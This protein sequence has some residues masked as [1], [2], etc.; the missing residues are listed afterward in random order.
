M[1]PTEQGT[2]Y[3]VR[4]NGAGFDMVY[5]RKLFQMFERLHNDAEFPGT[6]VGLATVKRILERH[7]GCIWAE[8]SPGHGATFYFKIPTL[9]EFPE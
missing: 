7:G 9:G 6:G 3:F 1:I 5:G 4:D 8:S 2:A